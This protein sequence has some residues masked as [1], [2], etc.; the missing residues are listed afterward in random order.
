MAFLPKN[1]TTIESILLFCQDNGSDKVYGLQINQVED[2]YM[3]F[4]ANG[5]RGA[6]LKPKALTSSPVT[7]EEAKILYSTKEKEKRKGKRG[8]SIYK[9]SQDGGVNLAVSENSGN[10]SGVRIQLLNTISIEEAKDL[11]SNPAW[12][13]QEK[14]DG[15]RRPIIIES[16]SVA[17]TNVYGE[18]TGGMKQEI[19]DGIDGSVNMVID[20]E[21]LGAHLAAFDLLEHNGTDLRTLGFMARYNHLKSAISQH[22]SIKLSTVAVST[23]EKLDL[24]EKVELAGGEGLVFKL[25]NAPFSAGRP[26]SGGDQLKVKFWKEAS[27]VVA[28]INIKNSFQMKVFDENGNDVF[29]GNCT[30]PPNKETPKVG[31]VIEVKYLYGYL[32]GSLFQPRYNKPRPEQRISECRLTQIKYKPQLAA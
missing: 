30:I 29:V 7:L 2:G 18:F 1:N 9:E 32:G 4:Y 17:G 3:V 25:A 28:A 21:D 31:D 23:Q 16:N 10:D 20:T 14:H 19:M 22:L 11:C 24:L 8:V 27:V 6:S 13:A 15:E 12:I 5:K 26:S